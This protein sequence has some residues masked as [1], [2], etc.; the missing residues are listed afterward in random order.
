MTEA[1]WE[2]KLRMQVYPTVS[3]ILTHLSLDEL[4]KRLSFVCL[5]S[6]SH[7]RDVTKFLW[8]R[9]GLPICFPVLASHIKMLWSM[10]ALANV[11]PS[12]EKATCR[13]QPR[14]AEHVC[15]GH[16]VLRSHKRT[17]VSP[18]PL[19][20]LEPSGENATLRTAS[21]CPSSV[22]EALVMG[23]IE[24][25]ASGRYWTGITISVLNSFCLSIAS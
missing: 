24:N 11:F 12:G 19:A 7:A 25:S 3:Q 5:I 17:V 16:S 18:E 21:V 23:L 15:S 10:P 20:S 4:A 1:V 2:L 6:G 14:W 13:T 9:K 8:P 22:D